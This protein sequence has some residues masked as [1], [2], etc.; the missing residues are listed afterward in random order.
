MPFAVL[1][2]VRLL[3]DGRLMRNAERLAH[4]LPNYS[5]HFIAL[6]RILFTDC[7]LLSKPDVVA[8]AFWAMAHPG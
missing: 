2:D 8:A 1:R 4:R 7:N 5:Q 3:L 6:E